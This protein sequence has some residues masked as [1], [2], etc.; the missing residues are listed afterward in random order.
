[1]FGVLDL[2]TEYRGVSFSIGTRNANDKNMRLA[3]TVG[4]RV[5]VCDN[6]AF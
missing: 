3:L 1:M 4:Y 6:M 5:M 2:E